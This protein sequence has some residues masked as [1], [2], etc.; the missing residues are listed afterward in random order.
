MWRGD[1]R[2]RDASLSATGSACGGRRAPVHVIA[3]VARVIDGGSEA[4]Y[5]AL[6][7][8]LPQLRLIELEA[9]SGRRR[10]LHLLEGGQHEHV[11]RARPHVLHAQGADMFALFLR[12][13]AILARDGTRTP[14]DSVG[15]W[16]GADGARA[17]T[18]R[19]IVG[20]LRGR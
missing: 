7:D 11:G 16:D 8:Q 14:W 17:P 19:T 3:A 18:V 2:R 20:R 5:F 6:I 9:R 13:F 15:L 10:L 4:D 12:V 1:A